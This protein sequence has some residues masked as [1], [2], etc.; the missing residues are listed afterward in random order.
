MATR[1][2]KKH[3][4]VKPPQKETEKTPLQLNAIFKE[5]TSEG[6]EEA[7]IQKVSSTTDIVKPSHPDANLLKNIEDIVERV[8]QKN[9][10]LM[11]KAF[12]KRLNKMLVDVVAAVTE[13]QKV[14]GSEKREEST[15]QFD[16]LFPI[17]HEDDFGAFMNQL[18][19]EQY[20]TSVVCVSPHET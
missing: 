8:V 13:I 6:K 18:D 12:D 17:Q 5:S 11:N 16:D 2:R 1:S 9:S 20:L 3:T 15:S 10:V 4:S 7:N 19:D 14:K